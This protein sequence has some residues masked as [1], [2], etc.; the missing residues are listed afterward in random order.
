NHP[1]LVNNIW[2]NPHEI[3]GNGI[4]DDAN[5]YIDDIHGINSITGSGDPMDDNNHGT[6]VAGTIG[7]E[8]NNNLGVV[9]VNWDVQ[10][11]AA[12]FLG[13]NGSGAISD[14]IECF[15]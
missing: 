6:H 12:K 11:G 13:G 7:A 10:I 1:D 15:N 8:G 14:A 4:D 3:A 5:G 2:T 9:G